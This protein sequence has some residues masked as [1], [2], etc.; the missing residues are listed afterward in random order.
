[1]LPLAALPALLLAFQQPTATAT[2]PA[3][4]PPSPVKR[5]EVQPAGRTITARMDALKGGC[6]R[7]ARAI[8]GETE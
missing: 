5:I 1:M 2:A 7:I 8:R 4:L 6:R 3:G